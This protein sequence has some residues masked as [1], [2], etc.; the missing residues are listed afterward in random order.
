MEV[1]LLTTAGCHLCEQAEEMVGRV[2]PQCQLLRVDIGDNDDSIERYGYR[3]PVL[4]AGG[5]EIDW[6]FSLLDLQAF[7][8]GARSAAE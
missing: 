5:R 1:E 2:A 7:L 6:P 8:R 4:R 3:I